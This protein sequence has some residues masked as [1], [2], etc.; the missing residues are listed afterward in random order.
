M[1]CFDDP[2]MK[3]V[4]ARFRIQSEDGRQVYGT[5]MVVPIHQ[6]EIDIEPSRVRTY[7]WIASVNKRKLLPRL[8]AEEIAN[9]ITVGWDLIDLLTQE[10]VEEHVKE[11]KRYIKTYQADIDRLAELI[12]E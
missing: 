5:R 8:Q 11:C 4:A 10:E 6:D 9:S 12:S 1:R 2:N 7:R 3:F